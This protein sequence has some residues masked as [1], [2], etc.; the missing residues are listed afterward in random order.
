MRT[1]ILA[2]ITGLY[3]LT[4]CISPETKKIEPAGTI[5]YETWGKVESGKPVSVMLTAYSTTLMANGK[6]KTQLRVAITDSASREITSARDTIRVYVTGNGKVTAIN[7]NELITKTDTAGASYVSCV[8]T[9]GTCNLL[10]MAGSE[11]DKVKVEA[12]SGKLWPGSHEIHTIDPGFVYMTPTKDQSAPTTIHSD[13][14]IGADISFLP[15][16]EARGGVFY[17]NGDTIDAIQLLK[18]HGFNYI[19]L[20]I[21]V[22]PENE[23]GYAPGEGYCGL[24]HTL[25]M[26]KRVKEA[27]LKLLLDFHYSDYWADP[28]QQYKPRAWDELDFETLKDSVKSYTER[29]LA[30]L[31]NQVTMPDMVQIGNEINHGFLWP[32]GYIGNPDQLAGLLQAGVEGAKAIDPGLPVMMHIALGGQNDESVF[33]LDNMIA[34]GVKFDIIGLSYYPRWHGTL[35]DLSRNMHDLLKRYDKPVNVVEYSDFKRE[36]HDI[37]FSLPDD[38]GRGACIWE[39]LGWRSGMFDKNGEVND[40]IKVYDDLSKKYLSN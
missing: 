3:L 13:R 18:E 30:A 22:N 34:R 31:K 20:R 14:M 26:A 39:P 15:Q 36:V 24:N 23:K 2:I 21:F 11:P 29:V 4:G 38:M 5:D 28:Q 40:L 7:G 16:I 8:L 1:K 10:F 35:A 25:D 27:G 6:D 33:W 9:D 12:R 19:R 32:D 17:E 37:V